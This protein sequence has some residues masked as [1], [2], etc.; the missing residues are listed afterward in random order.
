[1]KLQFREGLT[2]RA[3]SQAK[4]L[5]LL[6]KTEAKYVLL[7]APVGSGKSLIGLAAATGAESAFI[8]APQNVLLEQYA[9]EFPEI[10]IVKGRSHYRCSWA[11]SSMTCDVASETYEAQ[12]SKNCADYI[13]VRN[14]FWEASIS[15]TN[16]H[17]A[18]FAHCPDEV[19]GN[20]HRSLLVVD[21]CHGLEQMLLDLHNVR[22]LR[23]DAE[24]LEIHFG[25]RDMQQ[26]FNDYVSRVGR[27][28]GADN[29]R[30]R[31]LVPD[32]QQRDRM[33]STAR[34]LTRLAGHDAANPW[35][36]ERDRD[37]VSCRPLFARKM[38]RR[39]LDK[40]DRVLF[41]SGTPGNADTFFRN[42]GIEPGE[43]TAMVE[44][45]SD[46]PEGHGV[47]LVDGAPFV[48]SAA[49]SKS[50]PALAHMTSVILRES[51]LSKGLILCA[52][53]ALAKALTTALTPEFGYRLIMSTTATRD[54]AVAEHRICTDPTVLIATNMHEGLD[55][56]DGLARFLVIPKVLYTARD[57]WVNE[58][59]LLD[60]G[61]Y[62]RLTA[63]RMIQA[64]GRVVRGPKD[65]A[66][67]YILDSSFLGV[68]E[69]A[70]EEFPA[71]FHR[72]FYLD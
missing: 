44:V 3:G 6:A 5:D 29:A 27:D 45:D 4:A 1:M 68:V 35:H 66:R 20:S 72:G 46:F 56:R 36:I 42:L 10:P 9:R 30:L 70:P 65:W 34:K 11:G 62:N 7:S 8:V 52:S 12:H 43:D 38:A 60:P 25:Q 67:I 23:R 13:P 50:M 54:T 24:A 39:L 57:S 28:T 31:N 55:F 33:K 2:P 63:A 64:C 16:L 22:V 61:Y 40:A 21:E 37:W 49:L 41:M 59:E 53:Y 51:A 48:K 58:R 17:Y 32:V 26:L 18:C 47:R 14:A 19:G 71:Y 15:V 69:R